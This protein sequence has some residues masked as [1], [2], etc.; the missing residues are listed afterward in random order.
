METKN[1]TLV[2]KGG[3]RLENMGSS[4]TNRNPNAEQ[5]DISV[6]LL[7]RDYKGLGNYGSNG[8]IEVWK[9]NKQLE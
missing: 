4:D 2:F 7:S 5:S 8:V 3:Y 6:T 9:L 1:M